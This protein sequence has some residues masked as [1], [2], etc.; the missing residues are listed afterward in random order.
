[1]R[2]F[3]CHTVHMNTTRT[4]AGKLFVFLISNFNHALNVVRFLLGDSPASEFYE[5]TFRY[6]LS[7]PSS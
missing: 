6:T 5:P 7:V 3:Q 4:W 1:M 2:E